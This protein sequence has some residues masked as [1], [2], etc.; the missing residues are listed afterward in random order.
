M[1]ILVT[2][3]KGQLGYDVCRELNARGI[4]NKGVD[5]EDFDITDAA[6]VM[7][8]ITAGAPDAVIHCSAW[9]AVDK[10][11]D[12]EVLCQSVNE[13]G[14][15]NIAAACR[16][17]RAKMVYISTDYVFPGEGERFYEIDDPTSPLGVYG[18][19]KLGGETA[20]KALLD[21]HFIVRISWVF[22]KNGVNFIKTMLK[23]AESNNTV[24]V[25]CDQYGSPTYTAD[26]APLLCDMVCTEKYGTYHATNEGVCSWAE[27][28]EEVFRQAGKPVRVN[29]IPT[30][31]YPAK[32]KRPLNSRLSKAS[33]DAAGFLRLP[34]WQNALGRYLADIFQ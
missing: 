25:V 33:L 14:P 27:L 13:D 12:N 4:N 19:T 31:E 17:I 18:L 1:K 3:V 23:L 9:T 2:G 34:P 6:T 29:A 10:A 32:A 20:V 21:R 26:L 22:G 16:A 15:R 5:I 24:N 28:A 30:S 7:N 11:E 8:Y